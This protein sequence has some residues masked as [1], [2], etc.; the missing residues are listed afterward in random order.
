MVFNKKFLFILIS[1]NVLLLGLYKL[2]SF[3]LTKSYID[4]IQT[5]NKNIVQHIEEYDNL[6]DQSL[7]VAVMHYSKMY[8]KGFNKPN[9]AQKLK[10]FLNVDCLTIHSDDG[11]I[12]FDTDGTH[13]PGGKAY[14]TYNRKVYN[15]FKHSERDFKLIQNTPNQIYATPFYLASYNAIKKIAITYNPVVKK[16]FFAQIHEKRNIYTVLKADALLNTEINYIKISNPTQDMTHYSKNESYRPILDRKKEYFYTDQAR[17]YENSNTFAIEAK[18]GQYLQQ[19]EKKKQ[20]A[21]GYNSKGEYFYILTTEYSKE[22]LN[23]QLMFLRVVFSVLFVAGN[24]W[25]YIRFKKN[26]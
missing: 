16:F 20:L 19:S 4:Y 12:E 1:G 14:E 21:P 22:K 17:T 11:G 8:E 15:L 7:Q 3:S 10:D 18:C 5:I 6:T 25:L 9:D 26:I 23:K 13:L 2:H 24:Y